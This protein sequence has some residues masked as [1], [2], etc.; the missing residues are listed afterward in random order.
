MGNDF[1]PRGSAALCAM[2]YSVHTCTLLDAQS[3]FGD[4]GAWNLSGV[5]PNGDC[6]P[7]RDNTSKQGLH[8]LRRGELQGVITRTYSSG[9]VCY[10]GA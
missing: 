5:F 3:C 7:E 9:I 4:Q 6:S 1:R 10:G 2:S 8:V